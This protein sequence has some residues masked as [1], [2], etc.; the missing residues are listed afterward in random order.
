MNS[1][2]LAVRTTLISAVTSAI[3]EYTMQTSY[4]PQEVCNMMEK[5]NRDFLWG[6][7]QDKRKP[8][9]VAWDSVCKPKSEGGFG[10]RKMKVQNKAYMMKLG[11]KLM[12]RRD[13][14]W[15]KVIRSKYKCGNDLVPVIDHKRPE[16]NNWLGIRNN[17]NEVMNSTSI[18][19][20]NHTFSWNH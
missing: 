16:S 2:S 13:D 1:L 18:D 20:V 4:L 9:L 15:V 11:W 3:P 8:H 19:Y 7:S 17:W 10:L 12:N 14:L 6:S 5:C